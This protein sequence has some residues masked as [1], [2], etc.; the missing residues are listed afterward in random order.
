[1]ARIRYQPRRRCNDGEIVAQDWLIQPVAADT[2]ADVLV[3]AA[4]GKMRTPRTITGPQVI[5]LPEHASRLPTLQGD[6]RRVRAVEPALTPFAVAAL[7]TPD[8]A[9]VLGPDVDTWLDTAATDSA[10][11]GAPAEESREPRARPGT[12]D[13]VSQPSSG[14]TRA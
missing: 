4:L 11:S 10:R 8:H 3:E 6:D 7:L 2:V 13:L 1:V 14:R 5:R 12:S 9:V